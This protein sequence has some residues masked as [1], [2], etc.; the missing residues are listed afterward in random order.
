M[1]SVQACDLALH[2]TARL[3]QNMILGALNFNYDGIIS[4]LRKIAECWQNNRREL[5]QTV[6]VINEFKQLI[7]NQAAAWNVWKLIE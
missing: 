6:K 5:E 1:I 2:F 3:A 7:A 4:S